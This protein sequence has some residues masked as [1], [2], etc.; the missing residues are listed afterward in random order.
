MKGEKAEYMIPLTDLFS[1][2]ETRRRVRVIK[3]IKKFVFKHTKN[4]NIFIS[5]EVNEFVTKDSESFPRRVDSVLVKRDDAVWVYLKNGKQLALD[6]KKEADAKKKKEEEKKKAEKKEAEKKGEKSKEIKEKEEKSKE[7][8][9]KEEGEQK[10]LL[11]EKRQR[12]QIGAKAEM[13]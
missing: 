8:K 12:E 6:E 4:K 10:K 5:G 1:M 13:K 3:V 2:T 11:D 9:E 7:A